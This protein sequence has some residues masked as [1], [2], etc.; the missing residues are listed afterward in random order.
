M[1]HLTPTVRRWIY[2]VAIAALPLL[3]SWGVIT[4][5]DAPLYA[6]VVGAILVPSLAVANVQEGDI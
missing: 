4:E 3:I 5:N 2:G 1:K 6:A